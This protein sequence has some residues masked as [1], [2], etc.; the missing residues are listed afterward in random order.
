MSD[1]IDGPAATSTSGETST[2]PLAE[3]MG[4]PNFRRFYL[5]QL[6][7]WLVAGTMRF[8]FAYLVVTLTDW[9]AAEGLVV[10]CLGLPALFLSVPAGAMSDRIDRKQLYRRGTSAASLVLLSFAVLN[11]AGM[12]TPRWAALA[13]VLAGVASSVVGPAVN[14]AVPD[15]VPPQRL[16]NAAALQNGGSMAAQFV[17]S[18][19][20]GIVFEVFGLAAGFYMLGALGLVASGLMASVNIPSPTDT[21]RPTNADGSTVARPALR[22]E[23]AAGLRYGLGTEP[24]RSLL[25]ATLVLGTSF[26]VMQ[27]TMPRVVDEVYVRGGFAA[28][29]IIGV[30]GVGMFVSSAVVATRSDMHH[31]RNVA[32]FIGVGLGLGQ[33]LLS[34]MPTYWFAVLVMFCWGINAGIAMASHRTLVQGLTE[35]AM[36]G[37]VMGIMM[38]GFAGGAPIGALMSAILTPTIGLQETMT[39]TG[40]ITMSITAPLLWRKQIR[41]L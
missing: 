36:M 2:S 29:L 23:M 17:G 6:F 1:H 7:F 9:S 18:V 32:I 25:A 21:A 34:L 39:V 33:F 15:L 28:G 26:A 12:A 37:R 11:S 38:L 16:M 13:A 3:I 30:F 8:A 24:L 10:M 27:T 4:E 41:T 35:P 19:S 5:A 22:A 20:L 31:G 14:A 40:L